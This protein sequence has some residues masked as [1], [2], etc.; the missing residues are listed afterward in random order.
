MDLISVI[1]PVYNRAEFIGEAIQSILSQ[2]YK[3]F[4]LIIV[5]DAS[6]DNTL[7]VI[8]QFKD[9]R[10]RLLRNRDNYGVSVSRNKGISNAKGS[11]I[12]FMD[13]DDISLP[14]RLEKQIMKFLLDE[15]LMVCGTWLQ[16]M[17][18]EKLI[19]HAEYHNEISTRL[20]IHCSLS[21]GSVMM[22]ST[23]LKEF[24]LNP[25][26][27]YGEDYE[28]WSRICWKGKMFN[29]QEPLLIY[30]IH[31]NQLSGEN[32]SKQLHMDADIRL[33]LFKMLDYCIT[34]FPDTLIKKVFLF[35][36]YISVSEFSM[37]LN[38]LNSLKNLNNNKEVF[39]KNELNAVIEEIRQDLIFKI[40]YRKSFIGLTKFWRIK[41]LRHL[42]KKESFKIVSKRIKI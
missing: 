4:E 13:S 33:S 37:F 20:L 14:T 34:V 41:A 38:W 42:R 32:K 23:I 19:R 10:I 6:T 9:K 3:N 24:K 29:I 27:K 25:N 36:R 35:D 39:P 40:Y 22:K 15:D 17:N 7:E 30:R 18:S 2:T 26:L 1:I 21:I 8:K 28:L 31:K 12:A 16:M 5:D 11:F